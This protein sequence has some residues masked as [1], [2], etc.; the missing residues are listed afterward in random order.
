MHLETERSEIGTNMRK[1][2]IFLQFLPPIMVGAISL[3]YPL[4]TFGKFPQLSSSFQLLKSPV[5]FT[6]M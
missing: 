6:T 1:I 4:M 5:Q 2:F 3:S